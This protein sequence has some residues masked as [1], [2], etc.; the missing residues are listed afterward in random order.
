MCIQQIEQNPHRPSTVNT[1]KSG[2]ANPLS[3]YQF[4]SA[5]LI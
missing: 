3:S 4:L 5:S 2:K 1:G